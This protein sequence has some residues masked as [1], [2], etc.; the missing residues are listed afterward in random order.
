MSGPKRGAF[1]PGPGDD[2]GETAPQPAIRSVEQLRDSLQK[3]YLDG[4][5]SKSE[6]TGFGAHLARE[7]VEVTDEVIASHAQGRAS[8]GE[9]VSSL[10]SLFRQLRHF[11]GLPAQFEL[12]INNSPVSKR[13]VIG[14]LGPPKK[15]TF[16]IVNINKNVD[17]LYRGPT[18]RL[19]SRQHSLP[20]DLETG[21]VG[22]YWSRRASDDS[23]DFMDRDVQWL[24]YGY[25]EIGIAG[26]GMEDGP[27]QAFRFHCQAFLESIE[28]IATDAPGTTPRP[29]STAV[30]VRCFAGLGEL[31]SLAQSI[32]GRRLAIG[33]RRNLIRILDATT[34]TDLRHFEG[35]SE[36]IS[37]LAFSPDGNRLLSGSYDGTVRLWD[38]A[39]GQQL[40]C[41]RGH[42]SEVSSVAISSDGKRALSAGFDK[43]IIL[44][45]L[46]SGSELRIFL[47]HQALI[48][49]VAFSPK[50]RFAVSGAADQTV[51]LWDIESGKMLRIYRGHAT[52]VQSV[53]FSPDERRILSCS[54]GART[55]NGTLSPGLDDSARIWDTETGEERQRFVGHRDWVLSA[56][57]SPDGRRVLTA[58]GGNVVQGRMTLPGTD[59]TVRLWDVYTGK[60]I[61]RFDGHT[62]VVTKVF[63]SVDGRLAY[64]ASWDGSVRAWKMPNDTER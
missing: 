31:W 42:L 20:A 18:V 3:S 7:K 30:E 58:S 55:Q 5:L 1:A 19:Q 64:S 60:E 51:R 62:S 34:G 53:A 54:G 12:Q 44:W 52:G 6:I 39:S 29:E 9:S 43:T 4:L 57:F 41:C 26:G 23:A 49:S 16:G 27:I 15:I 63:F 28:A 59:N 17:S 47:G 56:A 21:A 24:N 2:S 25:L 33:D 13:E 46:E 38:V 40:L 22:V 48:S 45:S 8:Y 61:A 32:D 14:T 10:G 50:G 35:H 36:R 37:S 11:D